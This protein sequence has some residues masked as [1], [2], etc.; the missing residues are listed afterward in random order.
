MNST[1]KYGAFVALLILAMPYLAFADQ[2]SIQP[3]SNLQLQLAS[4]TCLDTHS[5]AYLGDVVNVINNSTI[6]STV[7]T[8]DIPKI[9]ADFA[10]LQSDATSNNAA[11][12]K[13]DSQQYNSDQRT[14]SLDA[15]FTIRTVHSKTVNS[16]LRSDNAQLQSAQKS[17]LFAVNQQRAQMKVQKF[18]QDIAN[19]QNLSGRLSKH[20]ANTAGLNQ[21]ID[22]AYNQI[23]AFQ[24]A[25][26]DAQNKTQLRSALNSFCLYNGCKS[27]DNF[28]FAAN[29]VIQADQTKLNLLAGQNSTASFQALVGQ[30]QTDL[31]NAQTALG[32]VG[33][34]QY[35]GTQS[36]AVWS[37][38]KT[39][40]E[41]IHQLQQIVNHKH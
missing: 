15:I 18:N 41:I 34:S 1:V 10:A 38:I 28:H 21:T 2:G 16:E 13:I 36:N 31:T 33:T 35:Q 39:A 8:T 19:A 29:A 17:C 4:M 3:S 20:G 11:Q 27:G 6:T 37:D 7:T 25:V 30:A 14:A 12:F 23:Q 22:N 26:N 40:G 32:Q 9:N 24:S 5:T